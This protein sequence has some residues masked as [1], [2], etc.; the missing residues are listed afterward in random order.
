MTCV[1]DFD[2][3]FFKNDY[4]MEAFC[5]QL[6]THPFSII[7]HFLFEKKD[8]LALKIKLLE[9]HKQSY[10]LGLLINPAVERWI[11]DNREHYNRVVLISASP[12]FFVKALLS[13]Y[14]LFDAVHGSIDHNLKGRRKVDFIYNHYGTAFDYLGDSVADMPVFKA[15]RN[16]YKVTAQKIERI[17]A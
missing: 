5:K 12:D 2:R 17:D 14:P 10:D 4:F 3:T 9:K 6:L 1:V 15:A 7:R 16:A 8:L 11:Q 13:S